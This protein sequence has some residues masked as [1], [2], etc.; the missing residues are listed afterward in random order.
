MFQ[1]STTQFLNALLS[2]A[3]T[4]LPIIAVVSS[5]AFTNLS[6]AQ[7]DRRQTRIAYD[8]CGNRYIEWHGTSC[9][10][11]Y[12]ISSTYCDFMGCHHCC[13]RF[14]AATGEDQTYSVPDDGPAPTYYE[15]AI[16]YNFVGGLDCICCDQG[17]MTFLIGCSQHWDG[18]LEI[19]AQQF[20]PNV[21]KGLPF[22]LR[23]DVRS[24]NPTPP[25]V[26][27][28]RNG[29]VVA[30]SAG[31]EF[32]A[33]A[34]DDDQ[35]AV[36]S[37]AV[38]TPCATSSCAFAPLALG[39]SDL[40]TSERLVWRSVLNSVAEVH[41]VPAPDWQVV[42]S[43][44][45]YNETCNFGTL[46]QDGC[47]ARVTGFSRGHPSQF[48]FAHRDQRFVATAVLLRKSTLKVAYDFANRAAARLE[49]ANEGIKIYELSIDATGSN[50]V[51]LECLPGE[52]SILA[53]ASSPDWYSSERDSMVQVS[54]DAFAAP[55][56]GDIDQDGGVGGPDLA[57][58]LVAWGVP[59]LVTEADLNQDSTVDGFDLTILLAN[60]G[61]CP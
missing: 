15:L 13:V 9:D 6:N 2:L 41:C 53:E 29:Y 52:I 33:I 17:P 30:E 47:T 1:P 49:I 45:S 58:L 25:P 31:P 43:D 23:V 39:L 55:C 59:N 34:S 46:R 5:L 22:T 60:W 38:S 54:V 42:C 4:I 56:T 16:D 26:T 14:I 18:P 57:L 36:Y 40:P 27:W 11:G 19:S 50:T 12:Y 35:G 48:D 44:R 61:A 8:E 37:A 51:E 28:Y 20:S 7:G 32:T 21:C 10:R 3:S 24:R